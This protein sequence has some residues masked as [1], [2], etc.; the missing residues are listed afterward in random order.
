MHLGLIHTTCR[1]H[2]VSLRVYIMSFS[3]DL[4]SEAVF[5]SHVPRHAHAAPQPCSDHAVLK[6]SYQGHSTARQGHGMCELTSAVERRPVGNLPAFGFFR[7]PRRF[8]RKLSSESQ[9]EMQ[10][11]SVKPSNVCHGR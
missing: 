10:L 9:T 5:D 1:A 4:H 8:P 7:L 6:S 11:A 3:F 2:A